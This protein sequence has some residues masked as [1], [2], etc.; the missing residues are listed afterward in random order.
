MKITTWQFWL[1]RYNKK[2][3]KKS[4]SDAIRFNIF[5][6]VVVTV[7]IF[8]V[9]FS[10]TKIFNLVFSANSIDY[11]QKNG[12]AVNAFLTGIL[13][14]ITLAYV[15]YTGMYVKATNKLLNETILSRKIGY[16]PAFII[17]FPTVKVFQRS[18]PDE[19]ILGYLVE[20]TIELYNYSMSS[21]LKPSLIIRCPDNEENS[22]N[23]SQTVEAL[24]NLVKVDP[25]EKIFA[26]QSLFLSPK[27]FEQEIT[28]P[29]LHLQFL[30][31]DI[32]RNLYCQSLLLR[33]GKMKDLQGSSPYRI[34]PLHEALFLRANSDRDN[35]FDTESMVFEFPYEKSEKIYSWNS[36]F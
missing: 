19:K 20:L 12:N 25:D 16:R 11:M 14:L 27:F 3:G 30:Y 2:I 10:A 15:I 6:F 7:V 22:T 33:L 23:I 34:K 17:Q 8:L 36:P 35:I 29:G 5:K 4:Y 24:R 32:E 28:E 26:S 21:A 9:V 1:Q 31:Q 13:V 18:D